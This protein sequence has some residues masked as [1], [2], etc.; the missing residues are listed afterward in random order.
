VTERARI[1]I[2]DDEPSIREFADRTLQRAGYTTRTA[3][4][5][6]EAIAIAAAESFE[7]L[8]TDVR[9]PEMTGDEVARQIRLRQPEVKVLYLTG[10][11]DQLFKE[12]GALWEGEAFLD[13][14][15][16]VVGLLEA[17]SLL[18]YGHLEVQG[19]PAL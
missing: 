10:Y 15:S 4:D 6:P 2:V 11:S 3:A 12:K 19:Q 1:L 18:L 16:T 9:M 8:L 17:V 13:K 7:L 14:P 5:G